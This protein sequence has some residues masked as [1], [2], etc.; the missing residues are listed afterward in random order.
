[1]KVRVKIC[2]ITNLDDALAAVRFGA[3]ALGFIFFPESP[4]YVTPEQVSQI[5]R[6]LP[7]FV[8]TVGV[9][10]DR[11]PEDIQDIM[12]ITGLEAAQLHGSEP[13]DT[14]GAVRC[15]VIKAIRVK[16][17]SDLEPLERYT[18]SAYLLDTYS[19]DSF[20]GTGRIFNWDI[21]VEAKRFGPIILAGGLTPDNIAEAVQHV[22]PYAVDVSS[23]VEAKKGLKDHEKLRLFI[24]RAKN[25]KEVA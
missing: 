25:V 16:E 20:G 18:V 1:M 12:E 23:G 5:V 13:P 19:P 9:F 11:T 21:A 24:Q 6:A 3:D 15:K 7:P 8:T 10:V 22:R 17:L 2:G 14:C 4:R